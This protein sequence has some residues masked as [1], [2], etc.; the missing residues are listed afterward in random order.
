MNNGKPQTGYIS[1]PFCNSRTADAGKECTNSSQCQSIC[2]AESME[3]TS[4]KC[5]EFEV[6]GDGCG[7]FEV[8]NGEVAELCIN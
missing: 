7:W 2:L 1:G 3:E 8:I 5:S 4:G 6:L